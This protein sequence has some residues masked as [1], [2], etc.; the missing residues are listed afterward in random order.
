VN[1]VIDIVN[2]RPFHKQ[3]VAPS[4]NEILTN[5]TVSTQ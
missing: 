4:F 2:I 5:A 3:S 1:A